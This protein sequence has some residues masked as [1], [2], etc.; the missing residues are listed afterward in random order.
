MDVELQTRDIAMQ[1]E[2]RALIEQRLARLADRY[3]K[4][5]RVHVTLKHGRHHLHGVEEADI[6]AA[7]AGAT[8]RAAKEEDQMRDAVH[9]ALDVLESQ[10]AVHHEQRRR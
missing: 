3:P 10:L 9:A 8:V 1:P 7:C 2:W 5:T 4:L 6:V